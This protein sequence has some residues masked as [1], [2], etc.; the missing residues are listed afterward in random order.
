MRP[1]LLFQT[2]LIFLRFV[3]YCPCRSSIKMRGMFL[4]WA[5]VWTSIIV[6]AEID[7]FVPSFPEIQQ[8]FM[9]SPFQV[10]F[11]LTLNLVAYG[12]ASFWAG[13]WGDRYGHKRVVIAGLGMFVLG[14][15]VCWFSP[16]LSVLLIGRIIQ[17]VGVAAPAVLSYVWLL[18]IYP[19]ERHVTL[20]GLMNGVVTM[21]V[22]GAPILGSFIT[23]YWGWRGNF[24]VLFWSGLLAW[25]WCHSCSAPPKRVR[26]AAQASYQDIY[27]HKFAMYAM[28]VNTFMALLYYVFVGI[29]PVLYREGFG[30]SLQDFGWYQGAVCL[31]FAVFSFL[32][33]V[34]VGRWGRSACMRA[35][36][37]SLVVFFISLIII[38]ALDIR[39]PLLITANMCLASA[40]CA[41]PVAVLYPLGL[42]AVPGAKGRISAIQMASRLIFTAVGLQL[43]GYVYDSTFVGVGILLVAI[44]VCILFCIHQLYRQCD[45]KKILESN[46]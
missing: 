37:A 33:G 16:T 1:I 24:S 15:V 34:M 14:S 22:A 12:I 5:M 30:V 23:L 11:V 28:A 31:I 43:A 13:D 10:E 7:I 3:V 41:V 46:H 35:S 27:R 44:T 20:T 38:T 21:A 39:S 36:I 6:G 17:G 45:L 40:A 4:F 25:L 42:N 9:L 26:Q 8:T 19:E 29:A 18:D 2:V 32:S